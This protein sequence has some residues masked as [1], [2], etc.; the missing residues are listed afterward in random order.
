MLELAAPEAE[1]ERRPV[2]YECPIREQGKQ[3]R[4]GTQE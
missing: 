4:T 3:S 1:P 2:D